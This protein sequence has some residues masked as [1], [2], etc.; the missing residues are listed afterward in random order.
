[1][2]KIIKTRLT[3]LLFIALIM[4]AIGA[5]G[6]ADLEWVSPNRYRV[7]LTV[8]SRD[9]KRSNSP[10]KAD[11]DLAKALKDA[12]GKG[13]FDEDTIEVVAYDST[14]KAKVFDSSRNGYE[15]M[16]V[17]WR[18]QKYYQV[19]KVT[20]SFV[21]PDDS[22]ASY[23]VYFDTKD[24]KRG[25][26]D[27]YPGLVGDGD[28]FTEGFKRREIAGCV[29]DCFA[30]F[31]GDGDL[32][33][34]VGGTPSTIQC[35][36]NVGGGKFVDKGLM[37]SS[38]K[39]FLL[40]P[41]GGRAWAVI[42]MDDWDSDGDQ[43]LFVTLS[44]SSDVAQ[45]IKYENIKDEWIPLTY[46]PRGP[47]LT[48][49]GSSLGSGWFPAPAFVDW[50]GD[51]KRDLML[52][53][54]G[55]LEFH[56]NLS[57]DRSVKNMRFDDGVYIKANG[58][59]I[60]LNTARFD[61]VDI[62]ND[63]DLDAFASSGEG[64]MFWFENIGTRTDPVLATGRVIAFFEF[65]DALGGIK[66]ADFDGDGLLD[67]AAGRFWERTNWPEQ[68]RLY[69][70]FYKNV[71]T[72]T[73][74]KFELRDANH[75]GLYTEQFQQCDAVR[76]NGVRA[77]DWNGD[78]KTDLIAS[79]TDGYTWYFRN[80]TNNLFPVYSA[81]EKLTANGE[82][83][84]LSIDLRWSGYARSD[85]SD[86]NNDGLLDLLVGDIS[87]R[88]TLYLNKGSKTKPVLAAGIALIL[89]DGKELRA[90]GRATPLI[91]D[92]DNDGKKDLVG[93]E[94]SAGINFYRNVG[95]DT[96]PLLSAAQNIFASKT[97]I[98]YPRPNMGS[99]VD[100]D[101]DGK[102]DLLIGE[103]ENRIRFLR[104]LGTGE[105]GEVPKFANATGVVLVESEGGSAQM[106]SGVEAK[107]F[108]G[109]GD[110]DILTGQGHGASGLRFY[111][112]DYVNDMVNDTFPLVAVG[113]GEAK[114][115][116]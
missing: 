103:F 9:I 63:G 7:L 81:G 49:N 4:S 35:Y 13:D 10:A 24:S 93:G 40:T 67:L 52:P 106:V 38:G 104:N 112:R 87:G 115:G 42:T 85:V 82:I 20:L 31:D 102:K 39:P 79:D 68:P 43:D 60:V 105:P 109:D 88:Y 77:A 1:M 2:N 71:G 45:L 113:R 96:A 99:F 46:M 94:D 101:G 17:P 34:F 15:K 114:A 89:K 47:L 90:G 55:M 32:D 91:C 18:I 41:D 57:A 111:E 36:E 56:R 44:D 61:F 70:C 83:I 69:G 25:K 48:V 50:D 27:R 84:R 98:Q 78:G 72:K 12:G 97:D 14:G 6:A 116:K 53:R 74:P 86:W 8:S 5:A 108:N 80:T 21:M 11:I 66:V 110:I 73:A 51:G 3:G 16:L 107:D 64:N 76:Q 23:A 33:L 62:D 58:V 75:G 19:D 54:N 95:T 59:N 26:P 28:K 30:D 65:M 37:T 100:W 29:F 22:C 92:F